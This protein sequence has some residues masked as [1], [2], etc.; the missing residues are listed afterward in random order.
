MM[1]GADH[2][3]E[4]PIFIVGA[5]RSGTTLMR[6]VLDGHEDIAIAPETGFMR[7]VGANKFVPFWMFGGEW[8]TRLGLTERQLDE[9]LATFYG[10]LLQRYAAAH[11]K[12]RWG[13]KTPWH[14]WHVD[15]MERL[16]PAATF[17]GIVR[18][19]G[20]NVGSL[21]TR[22]KMP[23][24]QAIRHWRNVNMQ[25]VSQ[26]SSLGNRFILCRYEDLVLRSEVT[27]RELLAHLGERWSPNVLEHH[28]IH[29]ERGTSTRVEGRSRSTDPIDPGRVA[30]WTTQVEGDDLRLL[31]AETSGLAGFFGYGFDDASRLEPIAPD[32][33]VLATGTVL[34]SRRE[35]FSELDDL[36]KP[37]VVPVIDRPLDPAD[38]TVRR[39]PST[40]P[41]RASAARQDVDP[42]RSVRL[43]GRLLKRV[44]R[45]LR[46]LA[47]GRS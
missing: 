6:L 47:S 44:R 13:E 39:K 16:W 3:S 20:G 43:G 37:P 24:R 15:Q 36:W 7:V 30:R 2:L 22:W 26:A 1:K 46:R 19:P 11:G 32:G 12:R 28:T 35:A 45:Q 4:A 29:R 17:I 5:M 33:Q 21:V 8:Y 9:E 31:I 10:G 41:S 14:V 27:L 34:A 23:I 42:A 38:V 25:L 40:V 18:H